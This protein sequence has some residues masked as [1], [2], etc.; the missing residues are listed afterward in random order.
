MRMRCCARRK[1]GQLIA[2]K[3]TVFR[4]PEVLH[5]GRYFEADGEFSLRIST[6][7]G[8]NGT[9]EPTLASTPSLFVALADRLACLA[10]LV[11][12]CVKN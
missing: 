9:I 1:N 8:R 7:L 11:N 4:D 2:D 12:L 3:S 6:G 5:L 10:S